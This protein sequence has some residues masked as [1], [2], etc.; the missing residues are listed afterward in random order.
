MNHRCF[1]ALFIAIIFVYVPACIAQLPKPGAGFHCAGDSG[2][3]TWYNEPKAVYYEG[4]H[5]RTYFGWV[6]QYTADGMVRVAMFD[7]ETNQTV[8]HIMKTKYAADDHN[9]PAIIVRPDGRLLVFYTGHGMGG[10]GMNVAISRDPEDISAFTSDTELFKIDTMGI[11]Y[12]NVM[13]LADEGTQGRYYLCFRG[14]YNMPCWV[15]SDDWGKTW[16][17]VVKF[18]H[19]INAPEGHRPYFKFCSNG[20]DEIH[21]VIEAWH[22]RY[23]PP[24][25]YMKYK[26]GA[27]YEPDGR[28]VGDTTNLP[29]YN[30]AL[31]TIW[32]PNTSGRTMTCW[33]IALDSSGV[34]VFVADIFI[35][36]SDNNDWS[37][38]HNYYYY[39]W[40]GTKWF[41][42]HLVNS[43]HAIGGEAGFSAGLTLDHENPN[44]VYL[45][46]QYGVLKDSLTF[47]SVT[48]TTHE[49]EKW[50]THDQGATW[51]T[52][53]I[54]RNS[55][56]K[57]FRPCVPRGH[58]AGG[59]FELMWM[60]G[61]YSSLG[62]GGFPD[63]INFYPF[64]E[65]VN[66]N[67][68]PQPHSG[69]SSKLRV[70][71]NGVMV[72]LDDPATTSLR[73]YDLRGR[74]IADCTPFVR[75]MKPG[76]GRIAGSEFSAKSGCFV[77]ELD[78]GFQRETRT[79]YRIP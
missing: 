19:S 76:T 34:P 35:N 40:N 73:V 65:I 3:W 52:F 38:N 23:N 68:N 4:T 24:V 33:D 45:A 67:E 30:S 72:T 37:L 50:V 48:D 56:K 77:I 41:S 5:K 58:K 27:F 54:T 8:V 49:I 53:P 26:K 28:R 71:D 64:D 12:P 75:R 51:D 74:L 59:K 46:R 22:R 6:N 15:H 10:R 69:H 61:D 79:W 9:H 44:I 13:F 11:V 29:I 17:K 20:K 57:N 47:S 62:A 32:N 63:K 2:G 14:L 31:D 39:R 21:M 18:F 66:L 16:S 25:Y 43:G 1:Q 60:Y 55:V 42:K 78:N 7:H 70:Y 36:S